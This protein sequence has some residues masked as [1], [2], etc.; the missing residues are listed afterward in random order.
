MSARAWMDHGTKLFLRTVEELTDEELSAPTA[1][2]GWTRRHI[3]AHVHGNANALRRLLDWAATG[4]ENRMYSGP[5]Q[6]AE[7][8]ETAAVLPA[9][10]LR[11]LVRQSA[12]ALADDM[13]ALPRDA[14]R[15]LVVTAQ[16]RTVPAEEVPYMRAREVAV[17]AVDLDHGLT[18]AD[19]PEDFNTALAADAVARHASRGKAAELA[20]WLTG[21]AVQV[22]E[23]G[24][25]L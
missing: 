24:P 5:E 11:L 14:W 3:L 19:L 10:E 8:I 16:G 15:H 18:F 7:E 9:G 1:L 20:A 4:V 2:K 12:K 23:L 21:R 22:P 6:R 17:H 13:D 25:W